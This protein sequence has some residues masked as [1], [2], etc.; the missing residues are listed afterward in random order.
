MGGK[1]LK[2]GKGEVMAGCLGCNLKP[3]VEGGKGLKGGRGEVATD[4]RSCSLKPQVEGGE[5]G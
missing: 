5:W 2:G 3:Q 1:G 4:C